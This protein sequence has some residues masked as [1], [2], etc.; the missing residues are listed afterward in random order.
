MRTGVAAV[1]DERFGQRFA[2]QF[3]TRCIMTFRGLEILIYPV[4]RTKPFALARMASQHLQFPLVLRCH[5]NDRGRLGRAAK[6]I[7][8]FDRIA[9]VKVRDL[10][11]RQ[12]WKGRDVRRA[13]HEAGRPRKL[14]HLDVI[15]HVIVLRVREDQRGRQAPKEVD[16]LLNRRL[17][18]DN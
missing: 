17:V 5:V 18:I 7:D 12:Q 3:A 16:R 4:M 6:R 1:L 9:I 2:D 15:H 11:T 13:E 10:R 8:A 14:A